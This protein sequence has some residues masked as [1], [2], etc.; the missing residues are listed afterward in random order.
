KQRLRPEKSEVF[1]LCCDNTK[2]HELTGFAPKYPLKK[3]L[4]ETVDWFTT[5]DNLRKYKTNIYNL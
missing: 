3:G 1:R 5:P 4:Q 2:I